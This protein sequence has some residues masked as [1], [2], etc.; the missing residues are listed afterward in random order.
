MPIFLILLGLFL[1][2]VSSILWSFTLQLVK[3]I[4][5]HNPGVHT[6]FPGFSVR[7]CDSGDWNSNVSQLHLSCRNCSTYHPPV[8]AICLALWHF[9]LCTCT[10]VYSKRLN[11]T[12]VQIPRASLNGSYNPGAVPHKLK[13]LQLSPSLLSVS[14][15]QRLPCFPWF[16]IPVLFW[17]GTAGR[18]LG[19]LWNS[20]HLF[21][22]IETALLHC[23][24]S[25]TRK[26][27]FHM[28]CPVFYLFT[29]K[30]Q[31]RYKLLHYRQK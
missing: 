9:T 24:F 26:Y 15:I 8:I 5:R 6:E 11:E 14:S 7:S 10:L 16:L 21:L 13:L 19:L 22:F 20:P 18:T 25:N 27:L 31:V 28:H 30:G 23:M 17:K 12:P 4:L 3:L 2:F 1:N 29:G